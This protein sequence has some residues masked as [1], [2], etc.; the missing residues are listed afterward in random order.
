MHDTPSTTISQITVSKRIKLIERRKVSV[1]EAGTGED[2]RE[3][4]DTGGG[5]C[6]LMKGTGH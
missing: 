6:A 1:I 5:K 3:T 4:G 2:G